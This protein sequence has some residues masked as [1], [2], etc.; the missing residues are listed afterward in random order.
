MKPIVIL[1]RK[2]YYSKA[3]ILIASAQVGPTIQQIEAAF[4]QV[5]P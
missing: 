1:S 4:N 5:F 2:E 3:G